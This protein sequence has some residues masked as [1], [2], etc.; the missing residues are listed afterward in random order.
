MHWLLWDANSPSVL[1]QA[2]YAYDATCGYNETIGYRA[3]TGQ[4]FA[5]PASNGLLELPLHIQD[6]A[7]F[8]PEYLDLS[9]TE[10]TDR[11]TVLFEHA[12]RYGGVL[13]LLWHDRS[14]APERHWGGF[15]RAVVQKLKA[16][17]CRFGTAAQVVGWFQNRRKVRFERVGHGSGEGI[18]VAFD[19]E[20]IEPPLRIR[21]YTPVPG[22][23]QLRS[24]AKPEFIDIP[25]DGA[26]VEKLESELSSHLRQ[27]SAGVALG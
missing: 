13:T 14:H 2:G 9:D 18:R 3:G 6:G 8:F 11:C 4:V 17:K 22:S 27:A 1:E 10:A 25:W 19:G 20:K 26:S 7:L 12:T 15:Y 23:S 16:M 5:L 24:A 21:V